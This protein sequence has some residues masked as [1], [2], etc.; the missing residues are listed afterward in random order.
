MKTAV[1]AVVVVVLLGWGV[2]QQRKVGNLRA[3]NADLAAQLARARDEAQRAAGA[4][5]G[6]A[7]EAQRILDERAELLRFR[8]EV[9]AL[10]QEKTAWEKRNH[11][12]A[13]V[14]PQPAPAQN[15]T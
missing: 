12:V 2:V 10:R 1:W 7:A 9:S 4:P 13:A 15:A 6:N 5:Q 14:A 3:E 11:G 8:A